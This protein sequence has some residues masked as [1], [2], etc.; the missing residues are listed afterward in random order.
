MAHAAPSDEAGALAPALQTLLH[1]RGWLAMLAPVAAGGA[2]L[3]L[4]AAVR[5]EEAIASADGGTGWT[6]TLCAGAAWFAGFLVPDLAREIIGTPGLCVGGS[7]A[8]TGHAERE[9]DGYR[10]GGQWDI[11]TGAPLATHYTF[12]AMLREG[13]R[14]LLDP[15]GGPRI[16]A[17]IVPA[18]SVRMQP[19]WHSIGL[20]ATASH[21]FSIDG[22]WVGARHGFDI[23]PEHA[24]AP[25]PLYRFPFVTLAFVTLAANVAGM[26]KHFLGLAGPLIAGRRHP[27]AGRMLGEIPEVVWVV[28]QA[29]HDLAA[30]RA[31]FYLLLDAMWERVCRDAAPDVGQAHALHAASLALVEAGR[32]A[33]DTL[34]PFCGLHAADGRSDINR[35]WRDLHTATQHAMLLPLQAP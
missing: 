20:R 12:N 23:A 3:A 6:V 11:A 18:Q 33:V 32:I 1:E 8:P 25:G 16:R 14:P 17:F 26:A 30:A 31:H 24:T 5:L 28:R 34:Y 35:V 29:G 10:L 15:Q 22:V 27:L 4:P 7:G 19:T 2:E 9:G 13:G 21:S